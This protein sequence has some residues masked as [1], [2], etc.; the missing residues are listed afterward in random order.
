MGKVQQGIKE[1]IGLQIALANGAFTVKLGVL[2]DQV[3]G[4]IGILGAHT[5]TERFKLSQRIG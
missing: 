2:E 1:L 5:L 4:D 3:G